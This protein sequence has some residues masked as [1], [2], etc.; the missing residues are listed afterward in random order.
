MGPKVAISSVTQY[1]LLCI[2][3]HD[4]LFIV[5]R[6]R[7]ICGFILCQRDTCSQQQ[8]GDPSAIT[9]EQGGEGPAV[10][11]KNLLNEGKFFP[12]Y[13]DGKKCGCEQLALIKCWQYISAVLLGLSV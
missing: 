12:K 5:S 1:R 7:A 6:C 11:R 9:D 2:R 13:A 3:A 8:Q 4:D 10:K